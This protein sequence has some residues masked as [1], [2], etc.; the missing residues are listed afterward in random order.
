ML[1]RAERHETAFAAAA[2][3]GV[4][5]F[6]ARVQHGPPGIARADTPVGQDAHRQRPARAI[7][8]LHIGGRSHAVFMSFSITSDAWNPFVRGCLPLH[9]WSF[10]RETQGA[11]RASRAAHFV[12]PVSC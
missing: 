7:V 4:P 1:E 9:S 8:G 2:A 11:C 3:S 12:P 6:G 10:A 5:R